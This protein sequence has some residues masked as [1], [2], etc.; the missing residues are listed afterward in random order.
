M[1]G[2][3]GPRAA[4]IRGNAFGIQLRGD[5]TLWHAFEREHPIHPPNGLD[6]ALRSGREHDPV[7]L[8][9]LLLAS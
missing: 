8:K 9:A 1:D 7:C 6:F 5:L 2:A 3:S 4:K